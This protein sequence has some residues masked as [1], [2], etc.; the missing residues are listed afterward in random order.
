MSFKRFLKRHRGEASILEYKASINFAKILDA[1]IIKDFA[2]KKI[3]L[4]KYQPLTFKSYLTKK[5]N[6]A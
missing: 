2:K 4:D 6:K 3:N 5:V 1:L